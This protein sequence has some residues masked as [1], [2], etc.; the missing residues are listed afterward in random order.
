MFTRQTNV[1]WVAFILAVSVIRRLKEVDIVDNY[2]PGETKG[3]RSWM[4][5]DPLAAEAKFPGPSSANLQS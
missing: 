4:M 1:I 2:E 5:F 3:R